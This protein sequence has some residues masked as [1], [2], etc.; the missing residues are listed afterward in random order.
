MITDKTELRKKDDTR[1]AYYDS[2]GNITGYKTPNPKL[3]VKFLSAVMEW[4]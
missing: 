4:K 1:E 2:E 3:I